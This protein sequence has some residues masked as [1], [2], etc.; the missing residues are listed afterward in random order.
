MLQLLLTNWVSCCLKLKIVNLS[1]ESLITAGRKSILILH[2]FNS[3]SVFSA[4]ILA[5]CVFCMDPCVFQQSSAWILELW[6]KRFDKDIPFIG[7]CSR[8]PQS[9]HNVQ[10]W[11]SL[12]MLTTVCCKKFLSWGLSDVHKYEY[13][14][15]SWGVILLL[16]SFN[17]I[18]AIGFHPYPK[19]ILVSCFWPLYHHSVWVLSHEV[20]LK[21]NWRNS[22]FHNS[23]KIYHGIIL[24]KQVKDM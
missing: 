12:F 6:R 15:M 5:F 14:I 16:Y 20:G 1:C 19:T 11:V 17:R 10:F 8:I 2:L 13:S 3:L 22:F 21:K 7:E 4:W 23:L 9:L 18:I 24:R